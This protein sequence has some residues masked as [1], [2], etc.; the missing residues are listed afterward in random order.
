M[1]SR[2]IAGLEADIQLADVKGTGSSTHLVTAI[3]VPAALTTVDHLTWF[4]TVRGRLGY[5]ATDNVLIFATGGFAFGRVRNEADYR[6][7]SGASFFVDGLVF[8]YA[9]GSYVACFA[10]SRSSTETGWTAGAGAEWMLWRNLSLK[11]EYTYINL[12]HFSYNLVATSV[13]RAIH[14]ASSMRISSDLE[15]HFVRAGLNWHF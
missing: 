13:P 14:V 5:L 2:W 1:A 15:Y 8:G 4:G 11:A 10:G 9:C 12:G 6:N 7:N 3:P